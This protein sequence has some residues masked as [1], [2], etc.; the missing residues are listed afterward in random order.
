[1]RLAAVDADGR[2]LNAYTGRRRIDAAEPDRPWAV[3]LA[4]G[5]GRFRLLCFDLDA[6]SAGAAAAA[7]R[8]AAAIA[9]LLA[10]AG[11]D[12][13]VCASGPT[14]GRHVWT[15]LAESVDA[16][17]IATL[18]R[19]TRD[20]CPS[21]DLS[22]LSNPVTGCVRPPG[23]PHRDGGHSTVLSGDLATLTAPAGTAAQV[24]Q[25]VEAVAA[26]V[27]DAEPAVDLDPDRPLPLDEHARLFIPGPRHELSAGAAAALQEDAAASNASAVLW[28]ILIAAAAAHWRHRDIAALVD[29]APGLEHVRSARTRSG[30]RSRGRVDAARLLR[31][32]WDKAVKHVASSD[33]QIGDDPTFD[34]RA[35]E[36][37]AY[38]RDVQTRADTAG[39]RW[40]HHGGPADRRV[41]DVLS[42]LALQALSATLEA[43]TRR[44]ALL[45]GIGR[46]TARTALL[47][48][49]RDGWIQHAAAAEGARG[50]RWRIS[51][52]TSFH[53]NS[54][55][56][57]SQADPRPAGAGAAER[58]TLLRQLT[59]RI[60]AATHDLFTTAPALGHH[61]GNTYARATSNSQTLAEFGKLTGATP[62]QTARTLDR[63]TDARVLIQS[64][65]GWRLPSV[66]RRRAAAVRLDVDGRLADR[67]RRYG[68]ERDL[69]AW[70]R[71]EDSWVRA[72]RRTGQQ[73]RP[74]RGQ[75][76]LLPDDGT[77]AFG[78]HPRR[79]DGRLDWREARRIVNEE[80]GG[81][82]HRTKPDATANKAAIESSVDAW[83]GE[84]LLTEI[85]GAVRVA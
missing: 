2:Q 44:L 6:K 84:R 53:S 14:G 29:T 10:G 63:L 7:E 60:T 20:L 15:A 56:A 11:L 21:L 62:A 12:A 25:L 85:L 68:I 42:V 79:A 33:R 34:T 4:D 83:P 64:R 47:R 17:T 48:L 77:H 66:D 1:M 49:A 36:I 35:D 82:A 39:G 55:T 67:E 54:D 71:A 70:W 41:L 78:P 43:D 18:A 81:V 76:A 5:E 19:L 23:A 28:R 38:I 3:Y 73:H 45:A 9:D 69:W 22:P 31:R 52:A 61:A 30:R 40:T 75:L 57:R 72:P 26:L 32:Q 8:D 16:D 37:A 27:D 24:R 46:E 65:A 13:V 58:I 51:R 74:G 80:R 59:T 50:A